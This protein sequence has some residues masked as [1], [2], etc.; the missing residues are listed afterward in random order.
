MIKTS[1][2]IGKSAYITTDDDGSEI[3]V[4]S[5]GRIHFFVFEGLSCIGALIKRPDVAY[6]FRRKDL[7]TSLNTFEIIDNTFILRGDF[8]K[9]SNA[10]LR[11]NN[12]K[13]N[14]T[15]IWDGM[16]VKT[17][18]GEMLGCVDTVCIDEN[19]GEIDY[20]KVSNGATSGALLG[21]RV[22]SREY[23]VGFNSGEGAR[24]LTNGA[25]DEES[26]AHVLVKD[27]AASV[28]LSGGAAEKA[29]VA[30]VKA[31]AKA[32]KAARDIKEKVQPALDAG[33]G[34]ARKAASTGGDVASR[35][36]KET[37]DGVIGFKDE[38]LKAMRDS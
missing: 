19:S 34:A 6:M 22:L 13:L 12:I 37:K 14:T 33:K 25:S 9:T 16:N 7:F 10:F 8:E 21:S 20:I 17:R 5:L 11:E 26:S 2:W 23:L 1:E 29:A 27:E 31:Q 30:S 24:L 3:S 28:E 4:K 18:S 32:S 36:F 35:K 38:F 15:V